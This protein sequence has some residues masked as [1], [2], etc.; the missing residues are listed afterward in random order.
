AVPGEGERSISPSTLGTAISFGGSTG[1]HRATIRQC[2]DGGNLGMPLNSFRARASGSLMR[3]PMRSPRSM[4]WNRS[5]P[6]WR[7][8]GGARLP[9]AGDAHSRRGLDADLP[10]GAGERPD[11]LRRALGKDDV[12]LP[13]GP[14][15]VHPLLQPAEADEAEPAVLGLQSLQPTF[16]P[17]AG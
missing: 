14:G 12:R 11:A 2:S 6:T 4:S 8:S 9:V 7:M 1:S 3:T 10:S 13:V 5:R 15:G 17:G 16:L